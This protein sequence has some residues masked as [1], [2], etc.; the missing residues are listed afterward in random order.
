MHTTYDFS[1][2]IYEADG[3]QIGDSV[4][5]LVNSPDR[6][7]SLQAGDTGVVCGFRRSQNNIGVRWDRR[8]I[9]GHSCDGHCEK[10]YG[11]Y[12]NNS[13]IKSRE[14]IKVEIEDSSFIGILGG[15][16]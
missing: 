8:I 5:L 10:G 14:D 4:E 13:Q 7:Y 2:G 6:N 9:N 16:K 12:V 15:T 11:W 3:F 1:G